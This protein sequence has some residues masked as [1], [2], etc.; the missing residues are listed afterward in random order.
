MNSGASREPLSGRLCDGLCAVF[1][2]WT[3]CCHAVVGAGG[4]LHH[5]LVA[6]AFSGA[7]ATGA[8]AFAGA[9]SAPLPVDAAEAGG[10]TF[11][12][13]RATG[14]LLALGCAIA[15]RLHGSSVLLWSCGL[16]LLAGAATVFLRRAPGAAFPSG[17]MGREV[18]LW[19]V[20]V[21]CIAL[22]LVLHRPDIDDAFY[23]NVAVSAADFPTEALLAHDRLLGRDELPIHQPVYRIHS[24]E[25]WNGAL[26]YLTGARAIAVFHWLSASFIALFV[27]LAH[28]KLF[29]LLLPRRWLACVVAVVFVLFAAGETHR[30][31]GNLAFSRIWQGK[32]AYLFVFMP[33]VYAYGIRFALR[34]SWRDG[35]LL[36]AA[37]I[38]A[39]GSSSTAVWAAP[40][41]ALMAMTC[42]LRPDSESLRRL[43]L[44]AL[45]C[46]YVLGAGWLVKGSMQENLAPLLESPVNVD[47]LAHA[48]G[49]ALGDGRLQIASVTAALGAWSV[50][51][52]G[53]ARRF[54]L[55]IPLIVW[56]V[57]LNPFAGELVRANLTG[58]SYWR[59]MWS[60]P[61]P[62][63]IA[64]VLVSPLQPGH[65]G[66]RR[67]AGVLATLLLGVAFA[68]WVPR[69]S[70]F[71]PR[72]VGQAGV[73]FHVGRP[74]LKV[75]AGPYFAAA[76]LN[77]SVPPGSQIV[78]P[79]PVAV[80]LPTF[81]HHSHPLVVRPPYL[82]RYVPLWSERELL[83]RKAMTA[84]VAGVR[85][86]REA[87]RVFERG[88]DHF[89]VEAV[90][91]RQSDE[92]PRTR[93]LL[94]D[95]RFRRTHQLGVFEI[96]VREPEDG[97]GVLE[98]RLDDDL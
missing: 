6:F 48:L 89:G 33:L 41:G 54:A 9:R 30:W 7:L 95:A 74:T 57:L 38:A 82:H 27:S 16:L 23:V 56:L 93:A 25:L 78:A 63:L 22:S 91:L 92:S 79:F 96:W 18:G 5:L 51:P 75:P 47:L 8:Y 20:G 61:I 36:A 35:L 85:T 88:L 70:V 40:A 37:Q 12:T 73:G 52:P 43:A 69:H 67:A 59:V 44:G 76:A 34:P 83:D 10:Q 62:I 39:V 68:L 98:G 58:P 90:C 60:L 24:Y 81:H 55:V 17:G 50:C 3:L 15:W 71:D 31:Y 19:S 72:N 46:V 21:A 65:A 53:L 14:L 1:A 26:S 64:L 86:G 11:A 77:E 80:W 45:T 97:S 28:A 2:L 32:A 4:N 66:G 42:A 94:I 49:A 13:L 87:A 84:Y 29:R